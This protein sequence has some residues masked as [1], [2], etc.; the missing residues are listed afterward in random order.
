MTYSM[1]FLTAVALSMDALAVS[2]AA[3]VGLGRATVA[4][5]LRMGGCFGFFQA[6]MP[7]TGWLLGSSVSQ[8]MEAYDHWVAFALLVLVGG[9]MVLES[10]K[11]EDINTPVPGATDGPGN[12]ST[13]PADSPAT[14]LPARTDPTRG[15]PLLLMGVATSIDALA[16][17]LSLSL[18]GTPILVP[19]L[20]IGLT[21]CIIS[22]FGVYLGVLA[23]KSPS[24]NRHAGLLGGLALIAIGLKILYDHQ[25]F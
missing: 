16:V 14:A 1:I 13:P 11:A 15:L 23:C 10:R 7:I 3:G 17:G 19:A 20:L 4:Q 6:I 2:I 18:L 22:F 25:V 8:Y 5:A 24:I 12:Q 21:T 9:H